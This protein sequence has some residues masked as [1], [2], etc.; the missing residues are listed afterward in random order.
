MNPTG[1]Q[2]AQ[3][4]C[5]FS[6]RFDARLD[7]V[8]AALA[9]VAQGLRRC[10]VAQDLVGRSEMILEE[11]MRNAI[12]HGYRLAPLQSVWVGVTGGQPGQASFWF[13]D[14][15]PPFDPLTAPCPG[16]GND[17]DGPAEKLL[18]GGVGLMLIRRLAP[19]IGYSHENGRNRVAI[20]W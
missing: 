13:E 14:S 15:A 10:G 20:C 4:S 16:E 7:A 6:T 17:M 5:Q 2:P 3:G 8:P 9:F 1:N 12:V 18:V 19:H 11:L